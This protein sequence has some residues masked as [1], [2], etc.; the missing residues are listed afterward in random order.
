MPASATPSETAPARR[1]RELD[2]ARRVAQDAGEYLLGVFGSVTG[3]PKADGS[4]VSEADLEADRRIGAALRE[5][6][7]GDAVLSEEGDTGYRG[8]ARVWIV[9]PL[10]GTT[11]FCHGVGVWGVSLALVEGGRPVV[12]VSHFPPLGQTFTAVRGGGAWEGDRRLS[13]PPT[14]GFDANDIVAIC[15]RTLERLDLGFQAK[16]RLLGSAVLNYALVAAGRA[17]A[18]IES[19]AHIWDLAAGWLLVEEAGGVI[20][21]LDGAAV[22]PL[23]PGDYA[24]AVFPTIAAT[25]PERLSLTRSRVRPR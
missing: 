4:L 20:E 21:T 18:S 7:P 9:D 15:S 16:G 6:F 1:R 5:A 23:A 3:R 8:E 11:N 25:G 13:L 24:D 10:D 22:W 19:T 17:G 2:G 14:A 12:G